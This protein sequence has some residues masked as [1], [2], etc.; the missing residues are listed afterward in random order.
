MRWS[1]FGVKSDSGI[2]S[3]FLTSTLPSWYCL[4]CCH[5]KKPRFIIIYVFVLD[6]NNFLSVW[7][8]DKCLADQYQATDEWLPTLVLHSTIKPCH[9]MFTLFSTQPCIVVPG[10]PWRQAL[11][12]KLPASRLFSVLPE[13]T[14][15]SVHY[16]I[17]NRAVVYHCF[18]FV[19]HS[20][21]KHL[22]PL[23]FFSI[24]LQQLNEK[25]M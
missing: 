15:W 23:A 5:C 2:R 19:L 10:T 12:T 25:V 11:V 13:R 7:T 24:G 21:Q 16:D 17:I 6:K 14:G 20:C 3:A 8:G 9:F 18:A 22:D 1:H 4:G